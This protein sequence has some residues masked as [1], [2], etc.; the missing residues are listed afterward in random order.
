MDVD[1]DPPSQPIGRKRKLEAELS[2]NKN[3]V[4]ARKRIKS[5]EKGDPV[6]AKVEK[7]KAADQGAITY[8]KRKLV[9]TLEYTQA[10]STN[11]AQLVQQSAA[12]VILKR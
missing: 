4:K 7:A 9:K 12:E 6:A 11:Q 5:L 2:T 10:S 8:A 3:T 1:Q